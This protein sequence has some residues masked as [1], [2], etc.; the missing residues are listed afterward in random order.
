MRQVFRWE[1]LLIRE[2]RV[3]YSVA[4]NKFMVQYQISREKKNTVSY[5]KH[6][7]QEITYPCKA[8]SPKK[9]PL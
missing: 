3:L 9:S 1:I 7:I 8:F 5:S 4:V 2:F 6:L